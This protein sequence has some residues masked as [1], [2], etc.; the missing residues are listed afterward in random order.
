MRR[1]IGL[2]EPEIVHGDTKPLGDTPGNLQTRPDPAAP[3]AIQGA[4]IDAN[5]CCALLFAGCAE[6]C[7]AEIK[8]LAVEAR[9]T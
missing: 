5:Q 3:E 1:S 6:R 8:K 9:G 2:L 7:A 4:R